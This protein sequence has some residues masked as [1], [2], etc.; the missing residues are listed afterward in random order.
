MENEFRFILD[1][2][3]F[4]PSSRESL[5][6]AIVDQGNA[7]VGQ[8]SVNT[9]LDRSGTIT[10]IVTP[11]PRWLDGAGFQAAVTHWLAER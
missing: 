4:P 2:E 3:R 10:V 9:L 1:A 11:G 5:A 7:Q 6:R 8:G